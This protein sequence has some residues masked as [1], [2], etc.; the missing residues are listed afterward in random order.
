MDSVPVDEQQAL[1]GPDNELAGDTLDWNDEG[2][3]RLADDLGSVDA[4]GH[5][6]LA[7][8][9]S[10][11]DVGPVQVSGFLL[12]VRAFTDEIHHGSGHL[13]Y[14]ECGVHLEVDYWGLLW[15]VTCR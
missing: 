5:G 10:T 4:F 14:F 9:L 3:V 12:V 2:D 8:D 15:K 1:S 7:E 13:F 6:V 11:D